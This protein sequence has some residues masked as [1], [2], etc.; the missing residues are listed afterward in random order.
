VLI[1]EDTLSEAERMV[2]SC[3]GCSSEA[4]I[5]FEEILDR[6]TG[7]DPSVTD[8]LLKKPGICPNCLNK[9]TEKTLVELDE[10]R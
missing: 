1:D 6:L 7:S 3:E 4:Q 5:F 10:G 8:Y 2:V 9:I